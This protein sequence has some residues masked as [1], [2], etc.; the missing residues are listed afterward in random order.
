MLR[1]NEVQQKLKDDISLI[2]PKEKEL[3][4]KCFLVKTTPK[5]DRQVTALVDEIAEFRKNDSGFFAIISNQ[6]KSPQDA[7]IAYKLQDGTEKRFDDLKNDADL[8]RLGCILGIISKFVC[9][10]NF[11]LKF[12]ADGFF[13][14]YKAQ[15]ESLKRL[16]RYRICFGQ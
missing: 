11:L 9:V 10:S 15:R 16:R 3:A 8:K 12:C 14:K 6:F 13:I 7:L 5:R 1:L 4:E 2:N